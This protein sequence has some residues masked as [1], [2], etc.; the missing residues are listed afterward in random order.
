MGRRLVRDM[1]IP[2]IVSELRSLGL[3]NITEATFKAQNAR[4]WLD[5]FY[6]EE[7]D[8]ATLYAWASRYMQ[9]PQQDHENGASKLASVSKDGISVLRL[10]DPSH[11]NRALTNIKDEAEP[12]RTWIEEDRLMRGEGPEDWSSFFN[13][14]MAAHLNHEAGPYAGWVPEITRSVGLGNLPIPSRSAG[15]IISTSERVLPTT[16]HW[17]VHPLRIFPRR[18]WDLYSNRVIPFDWLVKIGRAHV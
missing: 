1:P 2:R 18:I 6:H 13:R 15:P 4:M 11:F 3:Q 12:Y 10:T 16:K 5:Y 9:T 17:V 7:R 8:F 14:A